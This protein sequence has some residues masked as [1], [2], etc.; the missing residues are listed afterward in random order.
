MCVCGLSGRVCLPVLRS[1]SLQPVLP[2]ARMH[3]WRPY[4]PPVRLAGAPRDKHGNVYTDG[5]QTMQEEQKPIKDLTPADL[6]HYNTHVDSLRGGSSRRSRPW[7]SA[8][9]STSLGSSSSGY[10]SRPSSGP[11]H[12]ASARK[13]SSRRHQA[14]LATV[15]EAL[16]PL[17]C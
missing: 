15:R 4:G 13:P 10:S 8:R 17:E 9:S 2:R 14:H 5:K 6:I 7:R 12:A 3:I 1:H 16:G 11:R